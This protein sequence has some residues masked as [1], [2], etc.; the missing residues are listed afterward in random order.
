LDF[1]FENLSSGNPV[2]RPHLHLITIPRQ[3]FFPRAAAAASATSCR[4][5]VHFFQG[6]FQGK[7]HRKFRGKFFP[8][9]MSGKIAIFRGNSF[10]KSFFQQ[11]PRNFPRK[12]TFRG[13]NVRKIGGR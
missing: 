13:K 11:I 3:S 1:W 7:F 5:F 9:K 10:E 8:Q 12:I 2:A 4:F 6:K